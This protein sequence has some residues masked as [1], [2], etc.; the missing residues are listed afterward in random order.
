MDPEFDPACLRFGARVC[1]K[2][3]IKS[4]GCVFLS[5]SD[6]SGSSVGEAAPIPSSSGELCLGGLGCGAAEEVFVLVNPEHRAS[7]RVIMFTDAVSGLG[8]VPDFEIRRSGSARNTHISRPQ[9]IF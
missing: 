8:D 5:S 7:D 4:A 3:F 1:L 9:W 2:S 6:G